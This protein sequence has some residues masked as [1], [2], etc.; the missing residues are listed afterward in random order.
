ME[1]HNCTEEDEGS[2]KLSY[3]DDSCCVIESSVLACEKCQEQFPTQSH[4]QRHWEDHTEW[5]VY[6]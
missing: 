2:K 3:D 4:L 1:N 6:V 5:L